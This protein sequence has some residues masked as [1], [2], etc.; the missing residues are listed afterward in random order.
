MILAGQRH[1]SSLS[2]ADLYKKQDS[3]QAGLTPLYSAHASKCTC[4]LIRQKRTV[5][6]DVVQLAELCWGMQ[7]SNPIHL[8]YVHFLTSLQTITGSYKH[9]GAQMQ[10]WAG[11]YKRRRECK[12]GS[13]LTV[14]LIIQPFSGGLVPIFAAHLKLALAASEGMLKHSQ[15]VH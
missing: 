2:A 1:A 8:K 5:Q 15:L 11:H 13:A 4:G 9:H 7:C 10:A 14:W 3:Q 6:C 12:G